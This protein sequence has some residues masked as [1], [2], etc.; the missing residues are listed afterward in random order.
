MENPDVLGSESSHS[1]RRAA[2]RGGLLGSVATAL[3]ELLLYLTQSPN[4]PFL[5]A[6]MVIAVVITMP[7]SL[8]LST[9][10]HGVINTDAESFDSLLRAMDIILNGLV[11]S[12]FAA[13]ALTFTR[14][15]KRWLDEDS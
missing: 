15:L 5:H 2:F 12:L 7:S 10:P 8:L 1:V 11:L 6:R 4:G 9:L 3:A 14:F 13:G